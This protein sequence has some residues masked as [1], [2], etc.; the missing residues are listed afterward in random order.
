MN[1][2]LEELRTTPSAL[3]PSSQSSLLP[4]ENEG[5]REGEDEEEE[6]NEEMAVEEEEEE[7][8]RSLAAAL[9]LSA[10][11]SVA[12]V[13]TEEEEEEVEEEEEEMQRLVPGVGGDIDPEPS[14][15]DDWSSGTTPPTPRLPICKPEPLEVKNEP[16]REEREPL[17]VKIEPPRE[18][19]ESAEMKNE[20]PREEHEPP[21]VKIEPT[22]E[23]LESPKVKN[24][25]PRG[26]HERPVVKNEPPREE[27]ESLEMK[28]ELPRET[29]LPSEPLTFS[30]ASDLFPSLTFKL[31]Q[32]VLVSGAERGFVRFVGHTHFKKGV[33]IGVEL[34]RPKGGNDGSIDGQRYFN[35]S[36]GYGVFAPVR[37]VAFFNKEEEEGRSEAAAL[38]LSA[39]SSVAEVMTEEEEELEEEKEEEEAEREMQ[40]VV[41]GVG[42]D[43]DLEPSYSDDWS[44]GT[45]PPTPQLPI[46][47]PLEVKNEPSIEEHEPLGVK[48]EPLKEE[49][50]SPEMKNEPPRE[51]HEP[52]VVKNEPPREEH[53]PL[54]VK[55]EPSRET[56]LPSEP[57]T[58]STA[59]D[60]LTSLTFKPG[61]RVLLGGAERGLV[62]FVGHTHFKEGVW[63]GVELQRPKGK[64]DGSIDGQRYFNCSPGYGVFAPV[65][66]VAFLNKEAEEEEVVEEAEREMQR[67]GG[68]R[69]LEPS[70][71]DDWSSGTTP[72]TPRLSIWK[73][74]SL[75][76]KNEPPREQL[77]SPEVKNEAPRGELESPEVK[78]EP[79][80]E[81]ELPCEPLT[82]S[83]ASDLLTSLT[84]KPGQRVLVGEV[85][86]GLVRFIGHTHFKEGVWIGVE[87]ERHKGK[88]DGSIDGQ[89]YFNCSPGYGVFA[90]ASMV[91]F[92][93]KEEEEEEEEE[94]EAE[95]EEEE[96]EEEEGEEERGGEGEMLQRDEEEEEEVE[97]LQKEKE[98]KEEKYSEYGCIPEEWEEEVE[99]EFF[100][101]GSSVWGGA[102]EEEEEEEKDEVREE[103]EQE[104]EEGERERKEEEEGNNRAGVAEPPC[105]GP[106]IPAPSPQQHS[107]STQPAAKEARVVERS[108]GWKETSP[109]S[110][111]A[112]LTAQEE[113]ATADLPALPPDAVTEAPSGPAESQAV[114]CLHSMERLTN[115][116]VQ[117]MTNEA[118]Q[119]MH[120]IW[121]QRSPPASPTAHRSFHV[122][123]AAIQRRRAEVALYKRADRITDELFSLLL[124]SETDL[125]CTIRSAKGLSL[126]H[127]IAD[128]ILPHS[129]HLHL[130]HSPTHNI[131][132]PALP[133]IRET[134][135]P[136]SPSPP[137]TSTPSQSD[138]SPPGSPPRHL[139]TASAARVAAGEKSPPHIE[140]PT[141]GGKSPAAQMSRSLSTTSL[142]SLIDSVPFTAA[143]CMVPSNREQLDTIVAEAYQAWSN[144]RIGA[145]SRDGG[146]GSRESEGVDDGGGDIAECVGECPPHILCLFSDEKELSSDEEHCRLAYVRLVYDLAWQ[147]MRDMHPVETVRPVWTQLTEVRPQLAPKGKSESFTLEAVQKKVW[148]GLVRGQLPSLLPSLKFLQGT[149]RLGGKE[150]DFVDSILIREL[151]QEEPGWL[152]YSQDETTVKLKVAD[153][154]LDSLLSEAVGI[155]HAIYK[156]KRGRGHT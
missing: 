26:E 23:E 115:D 99:E 145:D 33:W 37:M 70:Y 122:E 88:N 58:F 15:S 69:D 77:E 63:I 97:V 154:I 119:T 22:R 57:L 95:A 153:G 126:R 106:P 96:E 138:H 27:H 30:T 7:E 104:E 53:K 38:L 111:A 128:G 148:A 59:S 103:E 142:S 68:D 61:Q 98:E 116:F 46:C 147:V 62:R 87:L 75:E 66:M 89:R 150:L 36:P 107:A 102:Q 25:P 108:E 143:Q 140:T 5:G 17:E 54:G 11:S 125:V 44:S 21:G 52:P 16:S 141:P 93:N 91:A 79:P 117:E 120:R 67:I 118:F 151:R 109:S 8:G 105:S 34:E 129:N 155:M 85:E 39:T 112:P 60:L 84:F 83:A 123:A 45:T 55:I 2:T 136:S 124:K 48:I 101:E 13:V 134:S 24:E 65:R 1:S 51:E 73:P 56:E 149:R 156:N 121:R 50:E 130:H 81:T 94:A 139:S 35:C 146:G 42:G 86:Q 90:P 29:E 6:E 64:N 43:R 131:T 9:P 71:S 10:T 28:I 132:P 127:G 152:E 31:G 133:T 40:R 80:R 113:V 76:L 19:L 110:P 92:L 82:F 18:E 49:L 12:E 114:S 135:P 4:S 3:A 74:E 72:H 47:K 144:S 14:Y 78:N 100:S 20:P 41:P 137:P 32:C